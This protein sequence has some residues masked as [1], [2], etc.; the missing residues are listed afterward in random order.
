[1]SHICPVCSKSDTSE[2]LQLDGLPLTINAQASINSSVSVEK[3]SMNLVVCHNC[4]HL[5]NSSFVAAKSSYDSSYENSLHYSAHFREHSQSLA[6]HLVDEYDLVGSVVAEAGAGPGHFL[7]LLVKEGV[8]TGY[9]FDPSY[10]AGRLGAPSHKDII[11]S[12]DLFPDDG[13]LSVDMALTQHVLEHLEDPVSLI[14]L[15]NSSTAKQ[16]ASIVYNE[17]PNGD[18]MLEN[19]ALWDLIYEHCSYFTKLSLIKAH[20]LAGLNV[21]QTDTSFGDQFLSAV[22][23][24]RESSKQNN[25]SQSLD[26]TVK[27]AI[28]FGQT[29]YKNIEKAKDDL[30]NFSKK[31][32]VV[33]WGAGSK[34][35]TYLNLVAENDQIAAVID[36]NPRKLGFGVPGTDYQI[37]DANSLVAIKPATVLISNPI[38]KSEIAKQLSSIGVETDI[39]PLWND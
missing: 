28:E 36:V 4:T 37:S 22:S 30:S 2:V 13:S 11:L 21:L 34:G 5:F 29:V 7:E 6:K 14:A 33:L 19:C 38:Y 20:E 31:G 1:M 25:I 24:S 17:V 16:G 35:M 27:L 15:L 8:K 32:P 18:F 9:G 26:D 39:V 12:N 10:D 23:C 3:G